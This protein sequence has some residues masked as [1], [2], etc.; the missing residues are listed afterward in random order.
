M[1]YIVEASTMQSMG[2]YTC[3]KAYVIVEPLEPPPPPARKRSQAP[4]RSEGGLGRAG[5][6]RASRTPPASTSDLPSALFLGLH[7]APG[8]L[9]P[10]RVRW[11]ASEYAFSVYPSPTHFLCHGL[12]KF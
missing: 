8:A 12:E 10:A 5:P 1:D 6:G 3:L 4:E 9:R 11:R 2:I 7:W